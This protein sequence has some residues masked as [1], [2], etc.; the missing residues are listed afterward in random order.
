MFLTFFL[1]VSI[2]AFVLGSIKR[3]RDLAGMPLPIRWELYPVPGEP[4]EKR[5]YGGSYLEEPEWWRKS[6]RVSY[7]GLILEMLKEILFMRNLFVNQRLHWLFSYQ[8]HAGIFLLFIYSLLL[9]T[10]ALTELLGMPVAAYKSSGSAWP[11]LI[12]YATFFCGAV[13]ITLVTIGSASL[14]IR[15]VFNVTLRMYTR[16]QEYFNLLFI[17]AA[18]VSGLLVWYKDPFFEGG[19]EVMLALLSFSS[20]QANPVMAVHLLLLGALLVYIPSTKMNHYVA[21]FF[22]YHRV[23]WDNEPNLRGS[24]MEKSVEKLLSYRPKDT[25]SAPHAQEDKVKL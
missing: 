14:F 22:T 3:F 23:L 15:R 12:Y 21:K 17:F 13:G 20:I 2:I 25:W 16:V 4:V 9:L 11:A 6:K 1:Y 10:G 24:R 8:L 5:S 7:M 18:A 19:R